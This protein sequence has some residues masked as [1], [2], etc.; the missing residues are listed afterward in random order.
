MMGSGKPSD[1]KNSRGNSVRGGRKRVRERIADSET[2]WGSTVI[3][4]S[5]IGVGTTSVI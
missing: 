3:L 1:G 2:F 4:R 5:E